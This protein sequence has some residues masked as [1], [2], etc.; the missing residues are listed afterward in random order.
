MRLH[1]IAPALLLL[2]TSSLAQGAPT[3]GSDHRP[4]RERPV[5]TERADE[6]HARDWGLKLE[7]WTRYRDL[8]L[9]LAAQWNV[10]LIGGS[11]PTVREG[12]LA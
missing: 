9:E 11:H 7:E 6:Q 3:F 1:R 10:H 8:M 12:L 2:L 4:S 5:A